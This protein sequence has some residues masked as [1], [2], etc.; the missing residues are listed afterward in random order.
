LVILTID[1]NGME[2]CSVNVVAGC[3]GKEKG[4]EKKYKKTRWK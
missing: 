4:L 2:V 1:T 3:M